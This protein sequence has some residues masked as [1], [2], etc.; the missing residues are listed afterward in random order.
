MVQKVVKIRVFVLPKKLRNKGLK[1]SQIFGAKNELKYMY[2]T[3]ESQTS[4]F[5]LNDI[6]GQSFKS[7]LL[8]IIIVLSI[9]IAILTTT[10][11]KAILQ[12]FYK[13]DNT[14]IAVISHV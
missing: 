13:Y 5:I 7:H 4:P 12:C 3:G 10:P 11:Y 8:V 14:I 2:F 1:N 6:H 9:F